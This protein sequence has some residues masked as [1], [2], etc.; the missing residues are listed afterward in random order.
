[1]R[2]KKIDDNCFANTPF[3]L[4]NDLENTAVLLLT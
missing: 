1:M 4:I 2:R 3:N